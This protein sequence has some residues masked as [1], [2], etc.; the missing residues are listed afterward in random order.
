MEK[1]IPTDEKELL[2]RLREGD[3]AAFGKVFLAYYS[4]MCMFAER[5]VGQENAEDV[6]EDVFLKLLQADYSFNDIRHLKAYLYRSV[7]H[8]CL[9]MLKTTTRANERQMV[10]AEILNES[11]SSYLAHIMQ[12]EATRILYQSLEALSPQIAQIIKM[13]YLDGMTNQ[14]AA[15][16]LG[17]SINTVK[18]QKQR[19][20]NKLRQILPKDQFT[21]LSLFFL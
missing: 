19:G 8:S 21:I 4:G 10:Y 1:Q 20:I 5:Y 18:T 14:E 9:D 7:R 11:Q 6:A 17:V 2:L 3:E 15:D 12:S 16:E 13:T